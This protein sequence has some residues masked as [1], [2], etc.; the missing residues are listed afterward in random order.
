MIEE[1]I[2]LVV[3]FVG[4]A[5]V[6]LCGPDPAMEEAIRIEYEEPLENE[7][8]VIVTVRRRSARLAKKEENPQ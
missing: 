7:D 6:C 8:E 3:F 1:V 2:L 4:M 5:F